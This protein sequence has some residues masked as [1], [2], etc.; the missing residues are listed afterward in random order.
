M[1]LGWGYEDKKD[2]P[3]RSG[4]GEMEVKTGSQARLSIAEDDRELP[5]FYLTN[6]GILGMC[7]QY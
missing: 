5:V 3:E 4:S 1:V 6:A 2:L 7:C